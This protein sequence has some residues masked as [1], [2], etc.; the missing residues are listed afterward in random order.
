MSQA[1]AL[2][3]EDELSKLIQDKYKEW[4]SFDYPIQPLYI[5]LA[6]AILARLEDKMK[7][8]IEEMYQ[9][10]HNGDTVQIWQAILELK[11]M[12]E[13]IESPIKKG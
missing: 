3:S 13:I 11:R 12:I 2:P 7:N 5:Y 10:S 9:E 8:N 6:K 1:K 4:E